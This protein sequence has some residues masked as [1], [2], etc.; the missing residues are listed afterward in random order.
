MI[1]SRKHKNDIERL[2][3][4]EYEIFSKIYNKEE[5][6]IYNKIKDKKKKELFEYNEKIFSNQS[7]AIHGFEL[8][9]FSNNESKKEFWKFK[10]GY[11]DIC[12]FNS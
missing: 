1:N 9:K 3:E 6:M 7:I 8:I 4:M 11:Y 10:E 5:G 12:K 2:N